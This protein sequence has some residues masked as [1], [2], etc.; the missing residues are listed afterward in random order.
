[1]KFEELGAMVD[2]KIGYG[3]VQPGKSTG[4]GVPVIKVNNI[5]SG[6]H[7]VKELETTDPENSKKYS[8]TELVGGELI[9]SIVG[10]VGKTAIVPK[11]FAGCNLVRATALIDIK[12][13]ILAY[14]VK[15][16]IDSPMG[17]SYIHQNLNTTVQPTLNIKSLVEMPIPSF[18]KDQIARTVSIL[19]SI[20]DKISLNQQINENLEQQAQ[21]LFKEYFC[22]Y[23]QFEQTDG[24]TVVLGDV[25]VIGKQSFNPAKEPETMLEHYSIPAFDEGKYPVFE[26]SFNIKSNKYVV[27]SDCILISKL[28]PTIK[29]VWKP[30]CISDKCVCSTE[31]IVF[32]AK[33]K[34]YTDFLYSLVDSEAFSAYMCSHVTGST[35]SRQRTTPSDTLQ[36]SFFLPTEEKIM[37]FSQIVHPMYEQMKVNAIEN[38]QLKQLRDTLLPKLMSG[39]IDVSDISI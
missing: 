16:Y 25:A 33:D 21:A 23:G 32:K 2:R 24:A 18:P 1:M 22:T 28:N 27:D 14:W 5:I 20:D 17:Q 26:P 15:Y 4:E 19:K 8:R 35:G 3:I 13:S 37:G 39:E 31:F 7:T 11:E 29:R 10:S 9:I 34:R 12:D 38:D 36:Y 6:L 30:Y